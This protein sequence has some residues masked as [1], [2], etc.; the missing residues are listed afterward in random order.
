MPIHDW[1]KVDAG[2]FH[3]F[4]VFWIEELCRGLNG[5]VLPK[6]YYALPE[7]RLP[8]PIPDVV[9]LHLPTGGASSES[10]TGGTAVLTSPVQTRLVRR[11]D[12]D[13]YVE[14]ANRITVRHRHGD[15]VA[16]IEIVSP[17][18]KSSTA[19]LRTFV[20]KSVDL[21]RA[22]IHLLVIDPFPPGKRDP[23]GIHA[24]IWGELSS[25]DDPPPA[26]K[27]LTVA[28]YDAGPETVAYVEFV[29]VDDPLPDMPVF[30]RLGEYVNVPL[31]ATYAA[32]WAVFPGAVKG[33]LGA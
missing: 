26:D 22:G 16:V 30:L 7:Q 9:T 14:K 3:A 6:E 33:L 20:T 10:A 31:E 1:T 4:H 5:G 18:N 32:S 19:A 24:A 13:V 23:A 11:R 2:L 8:G 21:I 29:A 15:V 28:A 12:A 17:G 25:D 27:P